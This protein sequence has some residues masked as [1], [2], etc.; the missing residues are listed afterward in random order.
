MREDENSW[1]RSWKDLGQSPCASAAGPWELGRAEHL[2][3]L[4]F[5]SGGC[6]SRPGMARVAMNSL[7]S[8]AEEK[9]GLLL[10]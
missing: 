4:S 10:L 7:P 2:P 5:G 1:V 3:G 8:D 9:G 6:F